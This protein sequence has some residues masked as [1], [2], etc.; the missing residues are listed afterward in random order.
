[1]WHGWSG[2]E[3]LIAGMANGASGLNDPSCGTPE[4]PK[5]ADFVLMPRNPPED[6]LG[7]KWTP[8]SSA[9]V[10]SPALRASAGSRRMECD[11]RSCSRQW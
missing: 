11:G 3:A 7:T 6:M 10:G 9:A 4:P 2:L 1:V 8:M 5:R